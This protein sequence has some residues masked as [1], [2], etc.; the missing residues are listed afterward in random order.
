MLRFC[1]AHCSFPES[2]LHIWKAAHFQQQL[3]QWSC[4]YQLQEEPEIGA[5]AGMHSCMPE[6]LHPCG[7]AEVDGL[8]FFAANRC[9]MPA[10]CWSQGSQILPGGLFDCAGGNLWVVREAILQARRAGG[11]QG[12]SQARLPW[13]QDELCLPLSAAAPQ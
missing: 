4:C 10:L 11:G 6:R 13:Q 9:T 12:A 7:T 2:D 3:W 8:S 1:C 5:G